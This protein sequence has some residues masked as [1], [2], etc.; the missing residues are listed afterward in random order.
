MQTDRERAIQPAAIVFDLD[1]TL[2][3]SRHDLAAAVNALRRD[4]GV[5]PLTE[6]RVVGM[7]GRG[8]RVLVEQAL[9]DVPGAEVDGEEGCLQR[10]L[11]LYFERCLET[12]RPYDG[13][14][15]MLAALA[16]RVPLA[17]LTNKP[18]RHA[19]KILDGLDLL[20]GTGA[21]F[22]EL[23]GGDTLATRKPDPEGLLHVARRLAEPIERILYVGDSAI[24]GE[25]AR[26]AGAPLA[27]VTW[28]LG[29]EEEL[30][31][32]EALLRPNT[33]AELLAHIR[34]AG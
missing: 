3:D 33:P 32:F 7:T 17:V 10:F 14:R 8:A 22:E 4:L 18:E 13:V 5:A 15:E 31:P 21:R 30:R 28:G 25:T 24:D 1:G 26:A 9:E 23:I 11:D 6:D 19:R 2:V 29:T 20:G 34:Q 16:G 12:T 27:L